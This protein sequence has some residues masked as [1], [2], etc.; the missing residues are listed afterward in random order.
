MC[1][2]LVADLIDYNVDKSRS[3][4]RYAN[5]LK[6]YEEQYNRKPDLK[7]W[8][9]VEEF[10]ENDE[11]LDEFKTKFQQMDSEAIKAYFK[12]FASSIEQI[13]KLPEIEGGSVGGQLRRFYDWDEDLCS[14]AIWEYMRF[15]V[16]KAFHQ[17]FDDEVLAPS[18]TVER[19]WQC[20]LMRPKVYYQICHTLVADLI[21]YNVDKTREGERYQNT[22]KFYEEHFKRKPEAPCWPSAEEFAEEEEEEEVE[23]VPEETAQDVELLAGH[24]RKSSQKRRKEKKKSKR[25]PK[26]PRRTSNK[27]CLK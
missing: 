8:P 18:E 11:D 19:V 23:A 17:D 4:E 15:L 10:E 3:R 9:A 7:C 26:R 14:S 27:Q 5:T 21:D 13:S 22:L 12:D 25:F 24:P 20:L 1:H 2:T 6:Y 16:L